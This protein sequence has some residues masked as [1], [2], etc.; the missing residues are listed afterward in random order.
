MLRFTLAVVLLTIT[1]ET[2]IGA[3]PPAGS[4]KSAQTEY[5]KPTHSLALPLTGIYDIQ[6]KF[7]HQYLRPKR[8]RATKYWVVAFYT[9]WCTVCND[10]ADPLREAA[11]AFASQKDAIHFGKVDVSEDEAPARKY[12]VVSFPNLVLFHKDEV[13]VKSVYEG[14]RTAS[15]VI[16]WIERETHVDRQ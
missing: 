3:A 1:I 12:G 4:K 9:R 10:I 7:F 6:P 5:H 16:A 15:D 13:T 14:P 11:S 8:A 2:V